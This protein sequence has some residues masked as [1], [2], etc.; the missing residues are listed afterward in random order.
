MKVMHVMKGRSMDTTHGFLIMRTLLF[1]TLILQS[2]HVVF[3]EG[4]THQAVQVNEPQELRLTV[5]ESKIIETGE[6]F[7]RASVANP[8]VADQI[9]LSPKQLYVAAK[10]VGTT[11][12]TLWNRQ[13]QVGN[14]FRILVAPDIA[15]LKE[16]LHH[17]LPDETG[18]QVMSSHEHITL[19]GNVSSME[20]ANKALILA[21]PYAPE[22]IVNLIQIG[23]VKQVMMEVKVAEMQR[24]LMKK[25][26]VNF[27]RRQEGHRDFSVGLIGAHS[28]VNQDE[29]V[30]VPQ[31]FD[32]NAPLSQGGTTTELFDILPSLATNGIFGFGLGK[33]LW[34]VYLD[35][36]KEHGLSKTM[37]EPTLIAE[38]GQRLSFWWV[39]NFLFPSLNNLVKSPFA[40]KSSGLD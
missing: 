29:F 39:G 25:L 36:L 14:V 31:P 13:G 33:D 2:S 19:A 30:R 15:R 28:F 21:E 6:A 16:Q 1:V 22:K 9:V 35:M 4:L 18:I 27:T 34:T 40:L 24:G 37:A 32:P 5:G 38:S 17:L 10:K 8:E 23:G 7:K 26:G 12:L 11:T 3:G 20:S